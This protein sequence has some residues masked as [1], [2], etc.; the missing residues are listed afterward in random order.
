M[1]ERR[2]DGGEEKRWRRG[3]EMEERKEEK[4]GEEGEGLYE[5]N[6]R[7]GEKGRVDMKKKKRTSRI[8][9]V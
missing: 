1:E 2:R 3:E 9:F 7:R 4:T 5:K 8:L 6:R